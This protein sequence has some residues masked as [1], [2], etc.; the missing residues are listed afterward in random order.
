MTISSTSKEH[1]WQ[2]F[3]CL[4]L[5]IFGFNAKAHA[6]N[7]SLMPQRGIKLIQPDNPYPAPKARMALVI[8]NS[9]YQNVNKLANPANDARDIA[10][11]L[12]RLGFTVI[13]EFNLA[14]RT[15]EEALA[16]FSARLKL[17]GAVGLFYY[18]GHGIQFDG[19]NYL[20]PID[21]KLHKP[22]DIRFE[23][24]NLTRV[25]EQMNSVDNDLNIV[26]LDA[27]RNNPFGGSFR[28]INR[29]LAQVNAPSGT[30]LAYATAPGDVAA[31]GDNRNGVYT[32]HLL[33]HIETP[34]LSIESFF[35]KVRQ[36]VMAQTEDNQVPWESSS[37]L[38]EF[39]FAEHH[40]TTTQ[41]QQSLCTQAQV[42]QRPV[43]CLF[44]EYE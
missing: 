10:A 23:A 43:N 21:A 25:L 3:I 6:K 41:E 17:Q 29:G 33:N 42:D 32:Q 30:I 7:N 26:I 11:A 34:G 19:T 5:F 8:G 20:L 36:G 4:F 44:G 14:H 37:L 2:L 22:S 13:L 1:F 9:R 15:M 39:Y 38:G 12:T 18:A 27:C 24:I 35:K 28:G 16:R 31:D 40:K